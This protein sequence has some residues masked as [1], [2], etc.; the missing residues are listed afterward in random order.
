MKNQEKVIL[1][2]D[3]KVVALK[4]TKELFFAAKQLHDWITE[5]N[6]SKKMGGILPS[7][8]ESHF[9]DVAKVLDYNSKLTMEQEERYQEIRRANERIHELE[10]QLGEQKPIDGLAEQLEYLSRVVSDW[11]N[12]YGFH[13]VSEASF[14]RS[15]IYKAKFSFMLEYLSTFSKTPVT[16]K[17]NRKERIQELIEEGWDILHEENGYSPKLVDNDNNRSRLINLIKSR[18]P[19]AKIIRTGNW[20]TD[21]DNAFT[22]RD[23]EVYIYDLHDI[24]TAQVEE[25]QS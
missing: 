8:I 3:Q 22:F 10:K 4:S 20:L 5:D 14:T 12:E 13:H 24:I 21:D 19:S 25:E 2:P 18:F 23:I 15:G 1:N 6:L 16:D 17:E 11:W 9:T 7:L